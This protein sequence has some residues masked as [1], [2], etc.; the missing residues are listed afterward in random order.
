MMDVCNCKKHLIPAYTNPDWTPPSEEIEWSFLQDEGFADLLFSGGP[1]LLL[2]THFLYG[3][4][5]V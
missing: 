3:H 5:V 1:A 4:G 2:E